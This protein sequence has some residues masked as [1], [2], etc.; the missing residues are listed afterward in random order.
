VQFK[1]TISIILILGLALAGVSL[2]AGWI[3]SAD[4]VPISM[5]HSASGRIDKLFKSMGV[6]KLPGIAPP[7]DIVLEDLNA[8]TVRVSDFKGKIVLLTFWTTWCPDCRAEIPPLEKLYQRFKDREFV[9]LAINLRE[10]AQVVNAFFEKNRLSF[11]SLLDTDG[12]I[13]FRF[14]IRSIPTAFILDKNG[15]LIA[16]IMGS[17]AWGGKKSAAL[18]ES[19][20]NSKSLP[21][22]ANKGSISPDD[23][24]EP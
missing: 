1:R 20:I 10:S 12:E 23:L 4:P 24:H 3:K 16:K 2:S 19:L 14:G 21:A 13:S 17:R 11:T 7:V 15:G 18:F 22:S 8:K 5:T 9:M 6:I